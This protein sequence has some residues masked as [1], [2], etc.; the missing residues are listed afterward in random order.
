M[1]LANIIKEIDQPIE[2]TQAEYDALSTA[3]KNDGTI[4]FITDGN[5]AIY[6]N[7]LIYGAKSANLINATNTSGS[8]SNVQAELDKKIQWSNVVDSFTTTSSGIAVADAHALKT[9]AD[10]YL[11]KTDLQNIFNTSLTRNIGDIVGGLK[12]VDYNAS[13]VQTG[14]NY[15][16]R[17]T[18]HYD[19]G[20]KDS[21]S[22]YL[23]D[24]YGNSYSLWVMMSYAIS[25]KIILQIGYSWGSGDYTIVCRRVKYWWSPYSWSPWKADAPINHAV[26]DTRYGQGT[27]SN[28]GHLKISDNYTSSAGNANSGVAASSQAV[29]NVYNAYNT[30]KARSTAN[31]TFLSPY[32]SSIT[33]Y[34]AMVERTGN[35]VICHLNFTCSRDVIPITQIGTVPEGYRPSIEVNMNVKGNAG[36]ENPYLRIDSAGRLYMGSYQGNTSLGIRAVIPYLNARL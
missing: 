22:K 6:K 20:H 3:Q 33:V 30:L 19:S 32:S 26:G 24:T 10:N 8:S 9:I 36:S 25:D 23:R 29:Y 12:L 4:Y 14:G 1:A 27:S 13:L 21:L 5:S 35:V 28:Y 31:I 34:R 15:I 11:S 7:G 16:M 2:L 17:N 18:T